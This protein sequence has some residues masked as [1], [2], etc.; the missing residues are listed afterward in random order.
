[1]TRLTKTLVIAAATLLHI[2]FFALLLPFLQSL[3]ILPHLGGHGMA[4]LVYIFWGAIIGFCSGLVVSY[5]VVNHRADRAK[6]YMVALVLGNLALAAVFLMA[7]NFFG[8]R[9]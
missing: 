1:M 9:W 3:G 4:N 6:R 7:V 5:C 8:L 2:S